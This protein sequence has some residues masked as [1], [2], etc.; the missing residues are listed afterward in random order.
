[1]ITYAAEADVNQVSQ[2]KGSGVK[3]NIERL[4]K[5]VTSIDEH[6][7]SALSRIK[8][9]SGASLCTQP[10]GGGEHGKSTSE[11]EGSSR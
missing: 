10:K 8:E 7:A 9:A 4:A 2:G 11:R 1:M 3:T 6:R 5:A